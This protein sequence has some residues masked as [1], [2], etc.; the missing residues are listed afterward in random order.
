MTIMRLDVDDQCALLSKEMDSA[1][2]PNLIPSDE[3]VF[4]FFFYKRNSFWL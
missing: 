3:I 1:W 4:D 2:Y